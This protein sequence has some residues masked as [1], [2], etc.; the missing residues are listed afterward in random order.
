MEKEKRYAKAKKEAVKIFDNCSQARD[1]HEYLTA[2]NV[3]LLGSIKL[4]KNGFLV[5]PVHDAKGDITSLQFIGADGS[6]K[7]LAG[8][9]IKGGYYPIAAHD[10]SK[11]KTLYIC[12]GYATG[13]TVHEATN[14]AV[15]VAFNCNNIALV[16]KMARNKYPTR[17]I[18][19]C[20]DNDHATTGN[21]GL[22][23]ATEAA[24]QI[25]ALLAVPSFK[26]PDGKS[27][28]ND[29]MC[30]EGI[31]K[32]KS[33]L[34][35]AQPVA[36]L[37]NNKA[38]SDKSQGNRAKKLTHL[39]LARK[40]VQSYG[41]GNL[42]HCRGTFLTW[43]TGV[44]RPVEE[45]QIKQ[46]IHIQCEQYITTSATVESILRMIKTEVSKE[47]ATLDV[48]ADF[49]NCINGEIHFEDGTFVLKPHDKLHYCV[50]QVPVAYDPEAT[51]P[52]FEQFLEEIFAGD[53]DK[54]DKKVLV[55][56]LLG[57][58]LL[59]SAKLEKFVMLIGAGANGKSVLL[60]V[61]E[62]LVGSENCSAVQPS[63]FDNKFQRAHLHGKLANIVTEIPEGAEIA[64]AALKAIVSGER[65]TV[66]QK[67]KNPFDIHPY[68]TCWF[69][70]NHMPR[71][72]DFSSALFRRAIILKFNHVF[73]EHEQDRHLVDK[74]KEERSGILNLALA[75]IGGVLIRGEFTKAASSKEASEEWRY[76]TD[77]VALF[78]QERC[79]FTEDAI[80][81][82]SDLYGAY[83]SWADEEGIKCAANK[84]TLTRRLIALGASKARGYKG[85][86]CLKG[87]ILL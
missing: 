20:A 33:I 84:N 70:T 18:V 24:S 53:V 63:Q 79:T 14:G 6:K 50:A 58:S 25:S 28:F 39:E 42:I 57:Y 45:M 76:E 30:A 19:I 36:T 32:V 66:E 2:K 1:D 22:T 29:L 75:G 34:E 55:C 62:M 21:P 54:E 69:A 9:E 82:S 26:A 52:R 40:V 65:T 72:R 61:V 56:E 87:I 27:D 44:W 68:A 74:L 51:A 11:D 31:E 16:A 12:E 7:F 4:F 86:R 17:E 48:E 60:S 73:Q 10:G 5:L 38:N 47:S 64:D 49:I 13:A 15:L 43:D 83:K 8:G 59:P 46:R 81:K 78:A 41:D 71:T 3:K 35:S 23:K 77:Q 85:A 37:L 80:T 67:S